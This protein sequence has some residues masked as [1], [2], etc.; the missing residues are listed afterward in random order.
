MIHLLA[1][2][3]GAALMLA[4][5]LWIVSADLER[6][7]PAVQ[8]RFIAAGM[9]L[10]ASPEA[11]TVLGSVLTPGIAGAQAGPVVA[12]AAIAACIGTVL[13]HDPA[14]YRSLL[15]TGPNEVTSA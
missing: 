6:G 3:A 7:V 9:L 1:V 11:I 10:A 8:V 12:A 14:A 2:L 15:R 4:A 5:A 13:P